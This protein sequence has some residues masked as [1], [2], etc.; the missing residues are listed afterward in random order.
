VKG[1]GV[2]GL[3]PKGLLIFLALLPQFTNRDWNWPVA[4][5]IYALG[6]V[7]TLT[8]AIFYLAPGSFARSFLQARSAAGRA[9][10]RLSGAAMVVI[11][12]MLVLERPAA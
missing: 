7:F 6:M 10:S 1:I 12:V 11:G 2:S 4:G 3:N 5:Q 9:V 8:C